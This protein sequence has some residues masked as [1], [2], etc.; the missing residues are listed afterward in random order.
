MNEYLKL[1]SSLHAYGTSSVL[2]LLA[3]QGPPMHTNCYKFSKYKIK[4]GS[5]SYQ[6]MSSLTFVNL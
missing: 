3:Y 4:L 6:E 1:T 5:L 2:I